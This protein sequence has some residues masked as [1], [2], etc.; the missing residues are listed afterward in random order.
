ME[1]DFDISHRQLISFTVPALTII[2]QLKRIAQ[3][4]RISLGGYTRN[5]IENLQAVMTA[6]HPYQDAFLLAVNNTH[7][8]MLEIAKIRAAIRNEIE[9][10]FQC[11]SFQDMTIMLDDY[12]DNYLNGDYYKLQFEENL[13]AAT[14]FY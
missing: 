6:R 11:S 2:P 13:T 8:F 12:L 7:H 5:I 3:P 10:I 14:H 9:L 1:A 4:S